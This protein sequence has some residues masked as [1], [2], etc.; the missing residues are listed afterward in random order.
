MEGVEYDFDQPFESLEEAVDFWKEYLQLETHEYDGLLHRFLSE[1]LFLRPGGLI[2][3]LHKRSAVIYWASRD[4][5]Q[6]E[7]WHRIDSGLFLW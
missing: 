1:R 4:R 5:T 7:P 2:H 6:R 3:R